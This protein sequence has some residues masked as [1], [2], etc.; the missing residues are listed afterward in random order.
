MDA[1]STCIYCKG[2]I[3]LSDYFCPHC[4]KKV[5]EK[6]LPT[7]LIRQILVY[8]LSVFLP[9]LGIWPAIK[10]L[11]QGDKKSITIGFIDSFTKGIDNQLNIYQ[12]VDF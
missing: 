8:L 1:Q 3:S 9:P 10:Y 2:N 6:L 7:T 4:G 11:R 12:G 5:K